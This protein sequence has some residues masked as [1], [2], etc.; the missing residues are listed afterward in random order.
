MLQM[1]RPDQLPKPYS[2]FSPRCTNRYE[3]DPTD[4]QTTWLIIQSRAYGEQRCALDTDRVAYVRPYTWSVRVNP[5]RAEGR[6]LFVQANVRRADGTK[7]SLPLHRLLTGAVEGFE[8]DHRSG[9]PLDC[10]MA[11]LRVVSHKENARNII[12]ARGVYWVERR[13][14]WEARIGVD[15][16][17]IFLGYSAT[18]ADALAARA[19]AKLIY[20]RIPTRDASGRIVDDTRTG[21]TPAPHR[22]RQDVR[23]QMPRMFGERGAAA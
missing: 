22:R 17:S 4:P 21:R 18:E 1:L 2:P 15:G 19:A 12:G 11:N 8:V 3:V 13:Q 9:F 6:Q 20:H 23:D 10:R 16:R 5:T 7:T 14:K